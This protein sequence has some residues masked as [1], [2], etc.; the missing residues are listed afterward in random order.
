MADERIELYVGLLDTI[1]TSRSCDD[2]WTTLSLEEKRWAERFKFHRHQRQYI[3]AHGLLRFALSNFVPQ[4]E[5]SDWSF[6]TDRYGRPFVARPITAR[7]VYFSLSHTEGCI[8]C[9]TSEH[10]TI[11]VD[12]EQTRPLGSVMEIAESVFSPD[13]IEALRLLPASELVDRFFDY[14]TLKEAYVK[15]K[16]KGLSFPLNQFSMLIASEEI[17]IRFAPGV[18]DDPRRW[19]FTRYSP[20]PAH[21]LAT[22]NSTCAS[23]GLPL[24]VHSWPLPRSVSAA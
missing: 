18:D 15:A 7:P 22:A 23:G 13:E 1:D 14:W 11:G 5:P 16:G 12:V 20:S 6:I 8:A 17:R 9:L 19:Q 24:I 3:F 2:F 21:R 4:V 10:E